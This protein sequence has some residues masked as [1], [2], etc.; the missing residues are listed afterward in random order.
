MQIVFEI[1]N[2]TLEAYSTRRKNKKSYRVVKL[3]METII[4]K[5][6]KFDSMDACVKL[7]TIRDRPFSIINDV[8]R[9]EIINSEIRS[10]TFCETITEARHLYIKHTQKEPRN[11]NRTNVLN[12]IE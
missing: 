1:G 6:T 8:K 7:V 2:R 3:R 5:K 9:S 10:V 11:G 4:I 12:I